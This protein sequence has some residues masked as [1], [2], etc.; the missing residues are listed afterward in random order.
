MTYQNDL[1]TTEGMTVVSGTRW[2]GGE[3]MEPYE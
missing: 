1:I 3:G 2:Y